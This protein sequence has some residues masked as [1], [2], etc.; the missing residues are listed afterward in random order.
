ML[1]GNNTKTEHDQF[2]TAE[3]A[4]SWLLHQW[5]KE[6]HFWSEEVSFNELSLNTKPLPLP[7]AQRESTCLLSTRQKLNLLYYLY[8]HFWIISDLIGICA[9]KPTTSKAGQKENK[10]LSAQVPPNALQKDWKATG[11]EWGRRMVAKCGHKVSP[12]NTTPIMLS[13]SELQGPARTWWL[14]I[15]EAICH[16]LRK[17]RLRFTSH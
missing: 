17:P 7:C 6:Q 16:Y 15:K 5:T 13:Y 2:A 9:D 4:K 3:V 11:G 12:S 10:P 1:V 14:A 8:E